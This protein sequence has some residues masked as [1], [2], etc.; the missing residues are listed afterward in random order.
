MLIKISPFTAAEGAS[1]IPAEWVQKVHGW[2]GLEATD[3]ARLAIDAGRA[4]Y[5]ATET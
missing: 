3:L 2:P 5:F 1:A 4:S